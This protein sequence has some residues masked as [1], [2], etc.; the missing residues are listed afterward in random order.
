MH[1]QIDDDDPQSIPSEPAEPDHQTAE[2]HQPTAQA[3]SV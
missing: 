3:A 1:H 2:E